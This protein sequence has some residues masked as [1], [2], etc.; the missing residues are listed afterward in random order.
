MRHKSSSSQS[1]LLS[2]VESDQLTFPITVDEAALSSDVDTEVP[3]VFAGWFCASRNPLR[4]AI[5]LVSDC[6]GSSEEL[7]L[8]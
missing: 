5:C 2:E 1:T 6:L 8:E 4:P 7:W 3:S